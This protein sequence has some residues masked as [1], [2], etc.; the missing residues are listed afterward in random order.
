MKA[1][2][3][4]SVS[5]LVAHENLRALLVFCKIWTHSELFEAFQRMPMKDDVLPRTASRLAALLQPEPAR[6]IIL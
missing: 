6:E 2:C 1:S 3:E 5:E 4:V